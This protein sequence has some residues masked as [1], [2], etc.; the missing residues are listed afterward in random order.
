MLRCKKCNVPLKG[1]LSVIPKKLFGVKPSEKSSDLCN[2]CEPKNAVY[3]CG[4]CGREVDEAVALT[5]VKTEEYLLELIRRDH[6]Q[7]SKD[8]EACQK[9]MDYYRRLVNEAEI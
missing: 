2:K 7:W 4:I 8:K 6:P 3:R 9:C 5:H 1:V